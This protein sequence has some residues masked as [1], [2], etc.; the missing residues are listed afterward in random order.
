[1]KRSAWRLGALAGLFL[2]ILGTAGTRLAGPHAR[3]GLAWFAALGGEDVASVEVRPGRFVREVAATGTLKAVRATPIIVPT[4]VQRQQ[5]IAFIAADGRALKAGDPVVAFDAYEADREAADGRADLAAARAKVE[6]ATAEGARNEQG[7]VLDRDVAK[8]GLDRARTFQ[9]TDETLFSRHAIIESRLDKDLYQA[10]TDVA[11][12]KLETSGRLSA[13]EK[14]LGQ[15]EAGKAQFK[16]RNAEKSLRALSVVAPHDGLLVLERN[17]R[18]ETTFVGDTVWPGEKI[19]EIPD[20]A[21]LEARVFVLEVDAA[22]LKPG[23]SA[24]VAIEGR[25][26][27]DY[28]ATV[29]RVEAL[30]KTRD[31]QS[32]V[33][34]FEATLSLERTDPAVMKPGQRVRAV[35][36]LEEQDGVLAIPRGAV[37]ERNGKRIVYLREGGRFVPAEVTVGAHGVARVVIASGLRSGDRI[38][39]RDPAERAGQVFAPRAKEGGEASK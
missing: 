39:L 18:G 22:G 23:L 10:R 3:P 1:M 32:P 13:A 17:W 35:I 8:E 15:I 26:G 34:Y 38:A 29:A 28:S 6:K 12:R 16:V 14:A 31:R 36:R 30:A 37:F 5:K 20:L 19:G 9:L 27:S 21:Q 24:R 7:L 4:E 11:G 25:P 33:K 2:L